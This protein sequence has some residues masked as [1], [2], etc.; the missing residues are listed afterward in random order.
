MMFRR[1]LRAGVPPRSK[2]KKAEV[3]VCEDGWSEQV[4]ETSNLFEAPG[5]L[6]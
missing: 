3:V 2:H 1:A 6:L 4:V 5:V